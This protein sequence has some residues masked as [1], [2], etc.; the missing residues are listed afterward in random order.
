MSP[1]SHI[2]AIILAAG[3][4]SRMGKP[5]QLLEVNGKCMLDHTI[6]AAL[7]AGMGLPIV[8]LGANARQIK[9]QSALLGCCRTVL[10]QQY[11][12]G[13]STSLVKGVL[14]SSPST[15]AYIFLLADQPFVEGE[16]I[17]EMIKE[18]ERQ[19]ADILY[20]EY[21]GQR[22]NPVIIS[23]KLRTL[24]LQ[25]KGDTGAKFLFSDSALKIVSHPVDT[26][27]V[28][29]DIDTPEDYQ[30]ICNRSLL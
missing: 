15:T 23:S 2:T 14:S 13:Q 30:N 27:A 3:T 29:R 10:N 11:H 20:P 8:V 6:Q 7:N 5:K 22:G 21:Q 18:F 4:S 16:L 28:I 1:R 12:M 26:N 25:A 19:K 9:S 24:L 17:R